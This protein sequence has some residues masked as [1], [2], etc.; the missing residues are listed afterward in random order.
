M[1]A[2]FLRFVIILATCALYGLVHSW[3]ASIQAKD[4]ARKLL[5]DRIVTRYYRVVYNIFAV[6]SFLPILA[7]MASLPDRLLYRVPMPWLLLTFAIQGLA[8]LTV[9]IGVL[10]TGLLDFAGLRQL[11]KLPGDRSAELVTG[12]LYRYVRHP[13]YTAGLVFLWFAPGMSINVLALVVGLSAYLVIGALFEERK[14]VRQYG[15]VYLDY[16]RVTPM[17]IP[18]MIFPRSA[19]QKNKV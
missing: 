17:L 2:E 1:R 8:A 11:F 6:L 19:V 16:R 15:Q 7:I 18:G 9:L 14:L 5:G 3:L 13:L 10:Q 4:L 12:G